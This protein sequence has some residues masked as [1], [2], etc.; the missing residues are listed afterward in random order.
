MSVITTYLNNNAQTPLGRFVVY[1]LCNQLC[2]KYSN[3][4]NRWSLMLVYGS[5]NIDRRRWDNQWSV[6][7]CIVQIPW[8]NHNNT[9]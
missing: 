7:D 1:M 4:L 5:T 6:V 8:Q 9:L 3:K 2:N